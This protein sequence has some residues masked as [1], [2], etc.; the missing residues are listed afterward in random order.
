LFAPFALV[1]VTASDDVWTD[2]HELR[3]AK[4][5][6]K[7]FIIVQDKKKLNSHEQTT[8]FNLLQRSEYAV[9]DFDLLV[10]Q[11]SPKETINEG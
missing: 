4:N 9:L 8:H 10:Q 3:Q 6:K 1:P 2:K 5:K 11:N 7:L